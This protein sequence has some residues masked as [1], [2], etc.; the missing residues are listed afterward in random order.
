MSV[1]NIQ[2][3][4]FEVFLPEK[5]IQSR[6]E[7]LAHDIKALEF[8][9]PP[10]FLCVLNGAFRFASDLFSF[11]EFPAEIE[12]VKLSSYRNMQSSGDVKL[13]GTFGIHASGKDVII[14]ED[15]VDTGNTLEFLIPLVQSA[16]PKSVRTA[17]LLFKPDSYM[18]NHAV[19]I[20]GF[21]IPN[22]FV[23]GYGLDYNGLGRQLNSIY[24][25]KK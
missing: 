8:E 16:N 13:H 18:G 14:L 23:V 7:E 15:I 2:G 22:D 21:E 9:N 24:K 5:K 1:V 6:I 3:K 4:E 19:D 10:L 12:F 20:K 17:A 25:H 11:M